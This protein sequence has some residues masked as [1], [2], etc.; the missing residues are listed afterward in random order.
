MVRAQSPAQGALMHTTGYSKRAR[1][2]S[3][4]SPEETHDLL[5]AAFNAGDLEAFVDVY[6]DHA[7][8]VV[9][10][11]GERISGK[12]EIREAVRATFDLRPKASIEV[13]DKLEADGL[14]LTL[15]QWVLEGTDANG[16]AVRYEGRG[17]IVSRRQPDGSWR[18][19]LDQ[20]MR[21]DSTAQVTVQALPNG[22][23][24]VAGPVQVLD[25]DGREYELVDGPVYLCR[26]GA[27]GN[28][29]FCDG[30]HAITGFEASEEA[31]GRSA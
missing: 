19:L 5:A 7:Q 13:L 31:P 6:D 20:P 22:P 24:R 2:A 29:P 10:P 11:T 8:L 4:R 18:I 1:R 14:A 26:C 30:M 27:S 17:T 28:K 16:A 15:A 25:S 3:A 21:Q 23:Y 9:P 12:A